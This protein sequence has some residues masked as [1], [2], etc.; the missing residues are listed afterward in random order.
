MN[1][2]AAVPTVAMVL[3]FAVP[4]LAQDPVKVNS[5]H[6]KVVFENA[7][8][9]VLRVNQAAGGKS[10]MHQH[11][12][13]IVIPLAPAKVRFTMPDG[14]SE[15]AELASESATYMAAG[16]HSGVNVGTEPVDVILVEFKAAA[17]G[18]ATL[19]SSRENMAMKV[20]AEGPY[21]VAYRVTADPNFQEPAGSKHDYD[22]VVIALS[23]A[24]M[25]LSIDGKPAK[26]SWARGDVQFIGRGTPHESK[27]STGKPVDFII[28]AVK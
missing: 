2:S 10:S 18:K 19:P 13:N 27:N 23:P 8:V 6:Y 20:H 7:N 25:S 14:K 26:T 4:G 28:V 12:D 15:D 16:S 5:E 17:P 3:L 11:P 1:A 9:R 24:R 21:A 22:Q